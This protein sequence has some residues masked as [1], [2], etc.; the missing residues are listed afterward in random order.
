VTVSGPGSS[1]ANSGYLVVGNY[2]TA[3]LTISNGGAVSGFVGQIGSG[4]GGSVRSS[5]PAL[6]AL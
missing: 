5:S 1:W 3:A 2:G 6:A 4:S